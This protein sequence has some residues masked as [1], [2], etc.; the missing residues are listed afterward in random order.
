[1]KKRIILIILAVILT[2]AAVTGGIFLFQKMKPQKIKVAPAVFDMGNDYYCVIFESSLK[3]SGYVKYTLDG[4]EKI[5][6]DAPSGIIATH[7]T[8]HK[9]LVPK[10]ELRN[11]DYIVGSQSVPFKFAYTA[12]KGGTAESEPIHFN[13]EEKEDGIRILAITDIHEM[14]NDVRKAVA[15]FE[16]EFDMV[17]MLGDITSSFEKKEKF[18]NH[19]LADAAELSGGRI[20]V[21]YARGNHETRG[22]YA[23]QLLQYFPT[24]TGEFFYTF[25]FGGLSAI[26]LDSG[27]DKEDSHEEYSGLVNFSAYREK[28]YKW[29]KSLKADEFT[30]KYKIVFCHFPKINDHFGMNWLTPLKE[31]GMN[32][33]VGGHHHTNELFD[34]ELPAL[35]ACGKYKDGWAATSIT[36]EDGNI[37][38]ITINTEGETILDETI[39]IE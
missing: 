10:N 37:S 30:G 21:V 3:G 11:N 17:V 20:P 19:I 8:V 18:T 12:T 5:L 7:D 2:L 35:D 1:M 15:H 38:M 14:E 6:W 9:I 27:E 25:N 36:L 13:G 26:V 4:K 29:I 28:E 24:E 16:E 22:E 23:S 31:L 32:L 33:I 34:L 39:T